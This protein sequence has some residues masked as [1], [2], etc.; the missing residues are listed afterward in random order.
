MKVLS[1]REQEIAEA[2][3]E[4]L[5]SDR[6]DVGGYLP[7]TASTVTDATVQLDRFLT[8]TTTRTRLA[9]RGILHVIQVSPTALLHTTQ[10]FTALTLRERIDA[11]TR[12]E[13]SQTGWLAIALMGLK[14]PLTM[15]AYEQGNNLAL[16]GFERHEI[17]T[18]RG[19]S[20]IPEPAPWGARKVGG[21]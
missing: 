12:A 8:A 15:A 11:L 5:L 2:V 9:F 19:T 21:P 3:C 10:R 4:A 18:P 14:V 7:P 20:K 16:T 13:H 1:A 6:D 17:T